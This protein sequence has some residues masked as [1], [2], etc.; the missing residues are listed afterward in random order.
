MDGMNLLTSLDYRKFLRDWISA[1]P[2]GT[3][4]AVAQAI[5]VHPVVLSQILRKKRKLNADQAVRLGLH[6]GL[7]PQDSQ[8]LIL[9]VL[10][11][12]ARSSE[13]R[14]HLERQLERERRKRLRLQERLPH[15][16]R[17]NGE[18]SA[19]F[20]SSW[21]YSAVRLATDLPG[22]VNAE[23][24]A[25]RLGLP[26]KRVEAALEFLIQEGLCVREGDRIR[27]GPQTTHLPAESMHVLS[28]HSHWR[29][30][31]IER[32]QATARPWDALH[33]TGPMA[34]SRDAL[35]E[36]RIEL[37]G[38]IEKAVRRAVSSRSETLACLNL[39]WFEF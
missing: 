18:M 23:A 24:I 28:H 30:R 12:Q 16:K 32:L 36:I 29:V 3:S 35:E 31:A 27:I 13:L 14:A 4:R 37:L 9:L 2:R 22:V 10:R 39:D 26:L 6:I 19:R 5:G 25:G 33:Y 17:G 20:Y 7:E 1:R 15:E 34:L 38:S 21:I 8:M 11:E